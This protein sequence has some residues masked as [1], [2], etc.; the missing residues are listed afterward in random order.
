MKF[1]IQEAATSWLVN[2]RATSDPRTLALIVQRAEAI[3]QAQGGYISSSHFERAYLELANEGTIQRFSG[4]M[5]AKLDENEIPREIITFIET[6]SA[7]QLQRAYKNDAE[8][9]RY[10]DLWEGS[11]SPQQQQQ[12]H[13]VLTAELYHRIPAATIARKYQTDSAFRGQV[14]ALI[15]R[16]EI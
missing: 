5:S 15:K 9:R 8:F 6:A 4:S 1:E 14:D 13:E 12:T 7:F 16:G 11:K 10:Y 2:K 3:H